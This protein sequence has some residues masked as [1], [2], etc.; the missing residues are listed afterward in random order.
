MIKFLAMLAPMHIQNVAICYELT[1]YGSS[2][3][4]YSNTI[5][6]GVG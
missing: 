5:G 2:E 3:A 1:S 4:E 6:C